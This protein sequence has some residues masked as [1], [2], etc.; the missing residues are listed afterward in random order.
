MESGVD[1]FIRYIPDFEEYTNDSELIGDYFELTGGTIVTSFSD[2]LTSFNQPQ[3]PIEN[4]AF[5]MTYFFG[6]EKTTTIDYLIEDA[7]AAQPRHR[8]YPELHTFDILIP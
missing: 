6:Y 2:L 5:L 8:Q 7:D 1:Q 4:K 3:S